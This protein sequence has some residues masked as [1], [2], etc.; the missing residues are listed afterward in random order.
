[1]YSRRPRRALSAAIAALALALA[2]A[3]VAPVAL[4][5]T[6]STLSAEETRLLNFGYA[7]QLGSGIYS[8]SG[9][10]L[11]I[12]RIPLSTTLNYYHDEKAALIFT[13]PV[14]IGI[15]DFEPNDV[16]AHGLPDRLDSYSLV[17]G[18][19]VALKPTKPWTLTPFAEWGLA[20]VSSYGP[21]TQVYSAGCRSRLE[22]T[23]GS[24][25]MTIANSLIYT[26]IHI[27]GANQTD[28]YGWFQTGVEARHSL[29]FSIA[30]K[31]AQFAPYFM[32]DLYSDNPDFPLINRE[33]GPYS[34]QYEVG[35][36]FLTDPSLEVLTVPVPRIGIGYRFGKDL[37]SV[38]IVLGVP[39]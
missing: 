12:Y 22:L 11:Q 36:T 33:G 17:P 29:G 32:Q 23:Q 37:S 16:L 18:L 8:I 7:T 6:P 39:F 13:Y 27:P 35:V 5:Q 2:A 34:V 21:D 14:T 9:R 26:G 10:T 19:G 30:G 25:G 28:D 3:T 24:W 31:D 38:R 20:H 15:F 4:A 1:L